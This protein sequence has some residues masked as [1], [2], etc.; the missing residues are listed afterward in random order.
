MLKEIILL[1]Y[2]ST[3][4]VQVLTELD[5]DGIEKTHNLARS[6]I[7]PRASN[8]LALTYDL[9]M[10][11]SASAW[12]KTCQDSTIPGRNTYL[13]FGQPVAD[14]LYIIYHWLME[15]LS[16]FYT[17]NFCKHGEE[18]HHYINMIWANS[19]SVGCAVEQ[20]DQYFPSSK[21]PVFLY[22]CQYGPPADFEAEHA[23][24]F[25]RS[26]S[27]CPL[28]TICKGNLCYQKEQSIAS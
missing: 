17:F 12:A 27:K 19:S 24:D 6:G 26:C 18:C 23:Y 20:C 7:F 2:F 28:G 5:R 22:V 21:K 13:T 1:V 15:Q 3:I 4:S 14:F 9:E 16:Y 8:M 11:D 10:E 25:G